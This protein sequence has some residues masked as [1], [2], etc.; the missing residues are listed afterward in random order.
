M[1]VCVS[2]R[3]CVNTLK[4]DLRKSFGKEDREKR[5]ERRKFFNK[6]REEEKERSEKGRKNIFNCFSNLRALSIK[7]TSINHDAPHERREEE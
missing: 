3:K 5:E 7:R 2:Q 6:Q 4:S 1:C